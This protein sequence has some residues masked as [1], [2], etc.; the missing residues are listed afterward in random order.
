MKIETINFGKQAYSGPCREIMRGLPEFFTPKALDDMARDLEKHTLF[1]AGEEAY[2]SGFATAR[3]KNRHTLEITWLAVRRDQRR[4]GV[5]A[6][7][8]KYIADHARDADKHILMLK[9]LAPIAG[10]KPYEATH[11]FYEKFG[12]LHVDTIDPYPGWGPDNPCAIYVKA[13]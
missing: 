13:L 12:F 5:G 7:L 3:Y 11:S 4:R 10:Y 2:P 9:T 8:I 6:A 1:V